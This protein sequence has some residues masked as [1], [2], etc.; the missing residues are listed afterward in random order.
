L[1]TY[2]L[3]TEKL[4][5]CIKKYEG[6]VRTIMPVHL[7]GY[8]CKMDEILEI[9]EKYGVKV[10]ED[11]C[12]AHGAT[13]RN[14]NVGSFGDA[15]A[16]SFYPSKNMTVCGDGGMVTTNDIELA[17]KIQSLRDV[18]RSKDKSYFHIFVGYTARMNTVN[19]AIGKVQLRY[20]DK[21]NE[22]R[23]EVAKT[24]NEKLEGVGDIVLPPHTKVEAEP[25]WHLYVVRT[26]YRDSLKKHIGKKGIQCGVHY[27]IP[28]HLQPPYRRL[29]F[30]EG[31]YPNTEKWAKEV[32]SLPMYPDLSKEEIEY[33]VASI[34]EFYE[35][36]I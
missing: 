12:Q 1:D 16:F 35:K 34:K 25:V 11:A 23:R 2:A 10:L 3:D 19:A 18:G 6:K 30:T 15:A 20:L 7:Y 5:E 9:S 27:P 14:E 26:K 21:W 31:M 4:E 28:V 17:D 13:Y 33:V 24:Y 32:I 29:G 22:K 8:P 36:A